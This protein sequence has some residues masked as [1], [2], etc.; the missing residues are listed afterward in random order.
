MGLD[1]IP[2]VYPC[3]RAGTAIMRTSEGNEDLVDCA[4]TRA[5]HGCPWE[6]ASV[7]RG[8]PVLGMF[9]TPCWYRGK[10]GT[11]MLEDLA[12]AGHALPAELEEGFYGPNAQGDARL[13]PEFCLALSTWMADRVEVYAS[14]HPEPEAIEEY[15]YAAWWLRFVA[16]HAD[17]AD[18]WW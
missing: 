1:D 9:G 7:G 10:A 16:E 12:K 14:L 18:A 17:G 13:S 4:A 2:H 5:A 3:A 11:W 15:R 8:S 6:V